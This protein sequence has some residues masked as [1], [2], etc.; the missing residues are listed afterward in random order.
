MK[1]EG[2]GSDFGRS[3]SSD[4]SN[5]VFLEDLSRENMFAIKLGFEVARVRR[6]D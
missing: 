3:R 2:D 6:G 5:V 4:D 1:E